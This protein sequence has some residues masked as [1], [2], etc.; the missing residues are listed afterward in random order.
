MFRLLGNN[1]NNKQFF[2]IYNNF[3]N[4]TNECATFSYKVLEFKF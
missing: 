2:L 4:F 3:T 1:L